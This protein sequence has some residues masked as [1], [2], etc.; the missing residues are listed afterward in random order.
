MSYE[1]TIDAIEAGS[2]L[3]DAQREQAAEAMAFVQSIHNLFKDN[4][5]DLPDDPD[6]GTLE[7][8]FD[9]VLGE[10]GAACIFLSED[11]FKNVPQML[12]AI[13]RSFDKLDEHFR[14]THGVE[15]PSVPTVVRK[16]YSRLADRIDATRVQMRQ[17]KAILEALKKAEG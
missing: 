13:S 9:G 5:V 2:K 10:L 3:D 14:D 4:G 15:G 8:L 12:R 17:S 11:S 16:G 7:N 1:D 6:V